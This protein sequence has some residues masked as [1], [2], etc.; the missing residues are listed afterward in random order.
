M[1]ETALSDAMHQPNTSVPNPLGMN[2]ARRFVYADMVFDM[3]DF[4]HGPDLDGYVD[5]IFFDRSC[6]T[7]SEDL[8][9][10]DEAQKLS[11]KT[12]GGKFI[13]GSGLKCGEKGK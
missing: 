13:G 10:E 2:S 7:W 12:G 8:A 9:T 11:V 6:G 1:F 3:S 5:W 4:T